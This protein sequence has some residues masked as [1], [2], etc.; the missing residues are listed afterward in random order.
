MHV[1]FYPQNENPKVGNL[2]DREIM[3]DIYQYEVEI[4]KL[5][6]FSDSSHLTDYAI[7]FDLAWVILGVREGTLQYVIYPA[8]E[9]NRKNPLTVNKLFRAIEEQCNCTFISE[10]ELDAMA[11]EW[12]E[13]VCNERA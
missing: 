12:A 8:S 9:D 1:W 10:Y 13:G 7:R 11:N 3:S 6:G 4:R 2:F 5:D